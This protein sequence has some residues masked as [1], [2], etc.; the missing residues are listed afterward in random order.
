MSAETAIALALDREAI[1]AFCRTWQITEL[2]LFGSV[3]KPREFREDS[4][5]DVL[6]TFDE[7]ARW[8]LFDLVT[9]QDELEAIIGRDVDLVEK[10][11][12][13]RSP[14]YIRRRHILENQ[15]VFYVAR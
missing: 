14:N 5:V 11:G 12:V 1:E 15:R 8:T 2:S 6:V 3:L 10:I 4:D 7:T 13:E 9:M